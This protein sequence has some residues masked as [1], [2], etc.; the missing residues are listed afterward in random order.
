MLSSPLLHRFLSKFLYDILPAALAS[1]VGAMFFAQQWARPPQN[2]PMADRA[3]AQAEQV[4]QMIRDE[5]VLMVEFL[6]KQQQL[7]AARQPLPLKQARPPEVA[8]PATAAGASARQLSE[9]SRETVRSLVAVPTPRS[10]PDA[11][12]IIVESGPL[13]APTPKKGVIPEILDA[14]VAWK[15][16]AMELSGVREIP[17]MIRELPA[18]VD[19]A[20][21]QV[22]MPSTSGTEHFLSASR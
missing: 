19:S 5:H 15:D 6:K 14:T 13:A 10:K 11:D 8:A 22:G 3:A 18:W 4:M 16:K 21:G 9:M 20:A 2:S 1:I 12:P 17:A 7:E